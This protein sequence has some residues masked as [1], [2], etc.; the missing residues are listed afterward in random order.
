MFSI[1]VNEISF[2]VAEFS[3]ACLIP[4]QQNIF[5][6]YKIMQTENNRNI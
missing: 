4:E 2:L 5:Y 3:R 6:T 1:A